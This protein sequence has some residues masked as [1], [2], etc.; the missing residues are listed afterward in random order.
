MRVVVDV[1]GSFDRGDDV[2]NREG[3]I[4]AARRND[5]DDFN[6]EQ[7]VLHQR[8]D[9]QIWFH[10]IG[11]IG[12]NGA[13][14]KIGKIDAL[15]RFLHVQLARL[16]VGIDAI[17]IEDAISRVGILLNLKNHQARA[18]RV[19]PTARQEHRVAGVYGDAVKTFLDR[20]FADLRFEFVARD[21]L[22]QADIQLGA[23]LRLRDVPHFRFRFAAERLR[24]V[25]GGMYLKRKFFFGIEN[26][27]QQRKSPIQRRGFAHQFGTMMLHEPMQ[28]LSS[29]RAVDNFTLNVRAIANFPGFAD[30]NIRRK[31]LPI[32]A[33]DVASAPDAFLKDRLENERIQHAQLRRGGFAL[34]DCAEAAEFLVTFA[35]TFR[36]R[37][38]LDFR[39]IFEE[40]GFQ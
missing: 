2:W 36:G 12:A 14:F 9:V 22:P 37:E 21:V 15:Q 30:R 32:E 38:R 18:D 31:R 19:D 13:W 1:D 40:S 7:R 20:A 6:F 5:G 35:Q 8:L 33:L 34:G 23:R 10:C 24:F 29:E 16:A 26:F 4:D 3:I 28:I 25:C 27:D 17:P 39:E 11:R